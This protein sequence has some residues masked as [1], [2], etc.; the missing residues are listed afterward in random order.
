MHRVCKLF[1]VASYKPF[2]LY[3]ESK[4]QICMFFVPLHLFT[5]SHETFIE[6]KNIIW[7]V[8]VYCEILLIS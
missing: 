8:R 1:E 2:N 4:N 3:I 7:N 5:F 6:G